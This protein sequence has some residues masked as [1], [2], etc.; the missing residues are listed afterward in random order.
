VQLTPASAIMKRRTRHIS[1][2]SSISEYCS[3]EDDQVLTKCAT[4]PTSKISSLYKKFVSK[5]QNAFNKFSK[6]PL[7]AS[8]EENL[9]HNRFQPKAIVDG[10]KLLLGAS[11]SFC[12][13]QLTIPAQTYFYEFQGIKHMS[14]PYVVS[15]ILIF[16]NKYI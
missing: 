4:V 13:T 15:L 2:R 8:I 10:F 11:G 5:T 7:L 16:L 3:D 9:L 12:P 1:D 6:L 14:T